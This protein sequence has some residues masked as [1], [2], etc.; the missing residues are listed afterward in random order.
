MGRNRG[1]GM[2]SVK[3]LTTC[4]PE[5]HR[6][7]KAAELEAEANYVLKQAVETIKDRDY[8]A[9]ASANVF[10]ECRRHAKYIFELYDE[11]DTIWEE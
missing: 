11:N 7:A 1:G 3:G 9:N 5:F 2:I 10:V 8:D 4:T 6:I